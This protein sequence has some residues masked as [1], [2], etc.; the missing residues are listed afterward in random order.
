LDFRRDIAMPPT[1]TRLVGLTFRA[2]SP[3]YSDLH[4]TA[5]MSRR[6]P[7][8]FNSADVGAVYVSREPETAVDELRR[9]AARDGV[10]LADMH[11][12]SILVIDLLLR[13]V[14]DLTT[15]RQLDAWGLSP[16]DLVSDNLERCQEAADVAGRLGAEAIRWASATG[17]GQSFALFVDQLRPGSHVEIAKSFHLTREMLNA[18]A[19]GAPVATLV[20]ELRDVPLLE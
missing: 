11:P 1:Q 14:V 12:R 2:T 13:D 15:S 4:K 3:R 20:T 7:G 5:A 10:S 9:R 17:A 19:A 16:G 6:Y 18:I 8:R